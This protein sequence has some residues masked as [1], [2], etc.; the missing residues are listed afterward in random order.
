MSQNIKTNYNVKS[1]KEWQ[2]VG[3]MRI[4]E[5]GT[6]KAEVW[7]IIDDGIYDCAMCKTCAFIYHRDYDC[8][9]IYEGQ[10]KEYNQEEWEK[11]KE[12]E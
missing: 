10:I 4:Y 8:E 12:Q 9:E 7:T 5:S 1:R 2:C 3:C 6:I 11:I